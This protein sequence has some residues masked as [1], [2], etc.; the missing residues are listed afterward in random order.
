MSARGGF[1]FERFWAGAA[2]PRYFAFASRVLEEAGR[3]V[4]AADVVADAGR[5][6]E[7]VGQ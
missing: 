7:L 3:L 5:G 6:Q 2:T 4:A 1:T